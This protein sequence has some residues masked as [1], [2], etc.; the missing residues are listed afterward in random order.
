MW[1][2]QLRWLGG[3]AIALVVFTALIVPGI[4]AVYVLG[5]WGAIAFGMVGCFML[6]GY[7]LEALFRVMESR[8]RTSH[9]S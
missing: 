6:A 1:R 9:G 8:K 4:L 7:P 3:V 2:L 5:L